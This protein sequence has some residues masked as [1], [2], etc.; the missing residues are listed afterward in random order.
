MRGNLKNVFSKKLPSLRNPLRAAAEPE[1]GY[2]MLGN[3][4]AIVRCQ[5]QW[6]RLWV[7]WQ[8]CKLLVA[9]KGHSVRK[10]WSLLFCFW[11]HP[12]RMQVERTLHRLNSVKK[13]WRRP[14]IPLSLFSGGIQAK[15]VNYWSDYLRSHI[16]TKARLWSPKGPRYQE[17]ARERMQIARGTE[18]SCI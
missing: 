2:S 14:W 4:R 11:R 1:E 13:H 8:M 18:E 5:K 15:A 10:C 17:K 6:S 3:E 12:G 7:E 9:I 16:E